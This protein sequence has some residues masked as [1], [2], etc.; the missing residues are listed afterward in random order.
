MNEN[1]STEKSCL[2]AV[3]VV[4]PVRN[5]D[6]FIERSLRAVF[7]QNYPSD[8]LEIVI[9][10]GQSNDETRSIIENL[11]NETKIPISVVDNPKRIAPTGLNIAVE[12]ARGEVII[13]VDGHCEIK[14]DYISNCVK[15]L[16]TGK[17]EGVGGPIE[18]VGETFSAQAIAIAMSS[19]FG[20]GGSA[21][22]TVNDR[23]LYVDTVAFPGYK[24][25]TLEKI[26]AFNEELVRNQDDEYNYRL[27]K[28]GG[29]ILLSP[30]I[31]SRY[32][33]RSNFK[34]LWR[35]YFQYGYWK[36]RVMQ[37]HPRQ[38][39]IRQLIPVCFVS[40]LIF[41]AFLAPFFNTAFMVLI[42]ILVVYFG[43]NILASIGLSVRRNIFYLPL[44][45]VAFVTL[46]FAYGSGMLIGLFKFWKGWRLDSPGLDKKKNNII[47]QQDFE[48]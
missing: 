23:Q 1:E 14:Q 13:R 31:R 25:E 41:L 27:R 12:K 11:K 44:L 39:S 2:P 22:R 33:S 5:E 36:V 20:V 29:K 48:A 3:S 38:M 18:T 4:M 9:A 15:H 35:Q 16:Q 21:F 19:K 8:L 42:C 46:H 32:Y 7:A 26:G 37:M 34:S 17:A 6:D 47:R 28:F 40:G 30:D 43:A 45:P 10:D 24:K